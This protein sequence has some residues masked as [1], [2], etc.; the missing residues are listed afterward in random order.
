MR[1]EL[2]LKL[3]DVDL[4]MNVTYARELQLTMS[5]YDDDLKE[6]LNSI[7][8]VINTHD[9]IATLDQ[10]QIDEIVEYE[11]SQS[12]NSCET[13]KF[14]KNCTVSFES[15]LEFKDKHSLTRFPIDFSCNRWEKK[16]ES[17]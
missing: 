15:S 4:T 6:I 3:G 14:Y 10:D 5:L 9:F 7:Y 8:D 17:K 12:L 2:I 16:D 1:K 13:C 11:K